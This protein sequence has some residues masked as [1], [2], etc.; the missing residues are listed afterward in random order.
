MSDTEFVF[1]KQETFTCAGI[2][3]V[4]SYSG[5]LRTIRPAVCELMDRLCDC[6]SRPHEN[7]VSKSQEIPRD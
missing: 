3:T 2:G 6:C 4:S 1:C 5:D 7:S